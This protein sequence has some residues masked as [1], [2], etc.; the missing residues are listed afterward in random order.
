MI[1]YTVLG[2]SPD[3]ELWIPDAQP[4]AVAWTIADPDE[5]GAFDAARDATALVIPE[6]GVYRVGAGYA[7]AAASLDLNE[8]EEDVER[9]RGGR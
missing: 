4:T 6:P 2:V 5:L 7:N 8:T 9:S 1:A 3:D